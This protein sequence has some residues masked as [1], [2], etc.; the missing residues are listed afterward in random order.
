[1]TPPLDLSKLYRLFRRPLA[2]VPPAR[3]AILAMVILT[4]VIVG[5]AIVQ[6]ARRNECVRLGYELASVS[7]RV[8]EAEETNRL[9][10]L[11]RATLTRPERIRALAMSLGM[12]TAPPDKIRVIRQPAPEAAP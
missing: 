5:A 1:V 3:T 7:E 12:V 10:E 8:R 2:L 6:V 4:I 9:L 11:E